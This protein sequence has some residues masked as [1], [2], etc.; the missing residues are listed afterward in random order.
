MASRLFQKKAKLRSVFDIIDVI[1]ITLVVSVL[2]LTLIFRVGCVQG[3][4]MEPTMYEGDQYII[5]NLFYTPKQSDIIVFLPDLTSEGD[6]AN[7]KLYVKRVIATQGQRVQIQKDETGTFRLYVDGQLQQEPY[8]DENQVT[9]PP[10]GQDQLDVT[11]PQGYVFVLGDNRINS[12]DSRTIGCIET[13]RIV[14]KVVLRFF[15]F[16]R[17]SFM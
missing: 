16:Q 3:Q 5:S 9:R 13:G 10:V 17:F 4:S 2:I 1:C 12:N 14:G 11:V 15:P 8:L 6:S 7:E